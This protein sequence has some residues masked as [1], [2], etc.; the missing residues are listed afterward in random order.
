MKNKTPYCNPQFVDLLHSKTQSLF[1][2]F[3]VSV[4]LKKLCNS[5]LF[6]F[7]PCKIALQ[8]PM[9]LYLYRC[10]NNGIAKVFLPMFYLLLPNKCVTRIGLISLDTM[11]NVFVSVPF[12][13]KFRVG[14]HNMSY[15]LEI[16]NLSENMWNLALQPLK[17]L[18]LR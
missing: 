8:M 11:A 17:P 13:A 1:V 10:V 12:I 7:L 16:N 18:Y 9:Y 14:E 5:F 6:S 2:C 15:A 3:C 4:H